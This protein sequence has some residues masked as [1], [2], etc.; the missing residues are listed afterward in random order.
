MIPRRRKHGGNA[1][2]F[3]E[4]L[5]AASRTNHS[6]LCVGLDPDS[7]LMPPID[8]VDFNRQII[9]ATSD[10]VC[11]YKPNLAFYEVLGRKGLE[12]LEKTVS[13]VPAHIPT[14]GDA[15]RGDI[16]NTARMYARALFDSMGFDAVTVNPYLGSDS[17]EPF[18]EYSDKGVFVLCRTSNPG[19]RDF[20][21]LECSNGQGG[22][23]PL[24]LMVAQK[25]LEWNRRGNVGLVVGATHPEELKQVRTTCPDLPLLIPGIG[26][27]GGDLEATVQHGVDASGEKA[28]IVSSRQIIYASQG[29]DY[30]RA[31]RD[32]ALLLRDQINQFLS[33]RGGP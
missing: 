9:E 15:K 31:A 16:A 32:A 5:L 24:Y 28:I 8:I 22:H 1:I 12:A 25:A 30:A 20:Q 10:L 33:R 7:N 3:I 6:L 4:K 2:K 18:L 23:R 27:Q 14:I 19:S 17:L 26:T 13:L 29:S 11:A 21:S